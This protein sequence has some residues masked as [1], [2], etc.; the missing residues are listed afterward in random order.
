MRRWNGEAFPVPRLARVGYGAAVRGDE[1]EDEDGGETGEGAEEGEDGRKP[2]AASSDKENEVGPGEAAAGADANG[3]EEEE[4]LGPPPRKRGR[5][6]R[7]APAAAG[8][9]AASRAQQRRGRRKRP[10]DADELE[11]DGIEDSS[12]D[13][14]SDMI[15]KRPAEVDKEPSAASGLRRKRERLMENVKDPLDKFLDPKGGD[16]SE[17][18]ADGWGEGGDGK[19][20]DDEGER[21]APGTT[22]TFR[23]PDK[24]TKTSLRFDSSD[25]EDGPP[26]PPAPGGASD[27]GGL[28]ALPTR[29]SYAET[30]DDDVPRPR[31][32]NVN[33]TNRTGKRRKFTDEEDGAI[34]KGVKKFGPGE[35][36][37]R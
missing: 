32:V 25:D 15:G 29:M 10:E 33:L 36:L 26:R 13:D 14:D 27:G 1:D 35:W 23:K 31:P 16:E 30:P 37:V 19:D 11:E 2:A 22:P 7:P 3:E 5:R 8:E 28:S 9:E 12:S 17:G 20:D 6:R 18:D 24:K 21:K 4:E 34:K